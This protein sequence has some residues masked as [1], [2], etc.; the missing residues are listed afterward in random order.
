MIIHYTLFDKILNNTKLENTTITVIDIAHELIVVMEQYDKDLIITSMIIGYSI[1]FVFVIITP[2][3]NEQKSNIINL[4]TRTTV[5]L[6]TINV[7]LTSL[8]YHNFIYD[9]HTQPLTTTVPRAYECKQSNNNFMN[10]LFTD[11]YKWN[12]NTI[13]SRRYI[14]EF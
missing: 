4:T 12:G 8:K 10:L 14:Y 7:V 3:N 11:W 9:N 13:A 1:I 5:L 2:I 6:A